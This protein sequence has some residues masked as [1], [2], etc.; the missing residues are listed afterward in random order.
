MAVGRVHAACEGHAH[1]C[2]RA[3]TFYEGDLP[4]APGERMTT[5]TDWGG[6]PSVLRVILGRRLERPRI[7]AGLGYAEAAALGAGRSTIRRMEAAEVARPRLA[8]AEKP[9]QVHGMT[10]PHQ[11]DTFPCSVRGATSGAGGTVTA[12]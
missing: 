3:A 1:A 11:L 7:R 2:G 8:D 5:E 12:M 9:L 6:V 4:P 10:G